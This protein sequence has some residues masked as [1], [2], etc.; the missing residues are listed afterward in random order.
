MNVYVKKY[1]VFKHCWTCVAFSLM[2]KP[3]E[4][5]NRIQCGFNVYAVVECVCQTE[6]TNKYWLSGL[7]DFYL[8]FHHLTSCF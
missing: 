7:S 2:W 1:I 3:S 4:E 6:H 8:D 5:S